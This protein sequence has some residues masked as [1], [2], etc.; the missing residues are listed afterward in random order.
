MPPETIDAALGPAGTS[1][2]ECASY[3]SRDVCVTF[4]A[5][6][7]ATHNHREKQHYHQQHQQNQQRCR[8]CHRLKRECY[9]SAK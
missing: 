7:T 4:I 2:L 5:R 9:N 3:C 6:V 8:S 1:S